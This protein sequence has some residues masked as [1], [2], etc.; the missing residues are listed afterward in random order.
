[1]RRA[2]QGDEPDAAVQSRQD[3]EIGHRADLFV[4]G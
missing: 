4:R 3:R 1:L 2:I